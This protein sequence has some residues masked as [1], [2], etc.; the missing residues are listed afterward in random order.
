MQW[1][2]KNAANDNV[3]LISVPGD[4]LFDV[5]ES[6]FPGQV[7]DLAAEL[8]ARL[9]E[10]GA[11]SQAALRETVTVAA[12]FVASAAS[13]F[14]GTNVARM[15]SALSSVAMALYYGNRD[16]RHNRPCRHKELATAPPC[17]VHNVR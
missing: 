15:G 5:M 16:A 14:E 7:V 6:T 11:T 8:A 4:P 9:R 3:L 10:A 12:V 1:A 2:L 17:R 13:E